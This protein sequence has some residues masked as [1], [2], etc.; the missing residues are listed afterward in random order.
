MASIVSSAFAGTPTETW[1]AR[2][3]TFVLALGPS[4]SKT[5]R[6]DIMSALKKDSRV[7]SVRSGPSNDYWDESQV[8]YPVVTD[9]EDALLSGADHIH[10]RHFGG[11]IAFTIH[12]PGKN[13]PRIHGEP[14][15]VD[16]YEA[17]WDGWT[18]VVAWKRQVGERYPPSAAGQVVVE[19]LRDAL[20]SLG[21]S[22][23]VQACSPACE[24]L[25]GHRDMRV[26]IWSG[27]ALSF[28]SDFDDPAG[29]DPVDVRFQ[30]DIAPGMV[31]VMIGD[32]V[33]GPAAAFARVKN[34]SRRILNIEQSLRS[35]TAALLLLDYAAIQRAD[36]GFWRA[37]GHGVQDGW[38]FVRGRSRARPVKRIISEIWLQMAAIESLQR[39]VADARRDYEDTSSEFATP[40]LFDGD[41]KDDEAGVSSVDAGFARSAIEN[42]SAR[43]EHRGIV[44]ATL[45]AAVIGS[46]IGA[47]IGGIFTAGG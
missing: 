37:L 9:D 38:W 12:V 40:L 28:D 25:F 43:M 29:M 8:F 10:S 3:G 20:S 23:L 15:R 45:V 21:H 33:F 19:I 7:T 17:T 18:A 46:G 24:H 39:S 47:A 31:A 14:A 36:V 42:K 11:A 35:K 16:E 4:R 13:Q 5:P 1:W 22:L 32:E 34:G 26:S 41:L 6:D 44:G 2:F 30:G 27:A